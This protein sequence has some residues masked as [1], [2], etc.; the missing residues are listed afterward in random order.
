MNS[1]RPYTMRARAESAAATRARILEA[2]TTAMRTRFRPDVRLA[3]VAAAAGV[4][5]QTVL[6]TFGSRQQLLDAVAEVA[7]ADVAAEFTDVDP[8]DVA[9]I[10]HAYFD[11]YEKAGDLVVRNIADESDPEIHEFVERGRAAHRSGI[12]EMFEARLRA[13]PAAVRRSRVDA[14]V[15]SLDV[16]IWKLLRRDLGRSRQ[17]AERTVSTMIHSILEAE[18]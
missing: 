5:V 9:G 6:R 12:E 15:C 14:L 11:H 8:G 13:L 2:A 3:D 7:V 16:Y 17:D 18:P 1:G 10:V 4:S